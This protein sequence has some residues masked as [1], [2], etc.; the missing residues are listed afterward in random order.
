VV[1]RDAGFS[2][3]GVLFASDLPAAFA[4]A[5]ADADKRGVDEI[6]V[7]GGSD[8]FAAVMADA[9]RLEVTRVHASPA[10]DVSFPPI[11]RN[12]WREVAR[13]HHMRGP[14][15]DCDFTTLTYTR[16]R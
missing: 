11:D 15:D 10:G 4:M 14:Q 8:V 16:A 12:L 1:T 7:I 3:P 13:E 5:R 9:D 6:M 2:A